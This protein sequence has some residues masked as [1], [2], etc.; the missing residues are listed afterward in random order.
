MIAKAIDEKAI[1]SQQ[2]WKPHLSV[3]IPP[4]IGA[5]MQPVA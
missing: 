2:V 4:R 3:N 1:I 5:I